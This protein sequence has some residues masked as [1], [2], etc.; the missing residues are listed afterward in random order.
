MTPLKTISPGKS[1]RSPQRRGGAMIEGVLVM[2]LLLMLTF[3]SVEYGY[4]FYVKHGV[5]EAAYLGSRAAIESGSTNT[6]VQTAVTNSLT[7]AGFNAGSFTVTTSPVTVSGAQ[8]NASMTVT[9]SCT[10]STVGINPL[11][12]SMGGIAP[13][14]QL[15]CSVAMSHE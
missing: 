11:P 7:S 12:V 13:T 4:A 8:P 10:W 1:H 2:S 3:G 6:T 5:Q 15:S 9:V 14:K